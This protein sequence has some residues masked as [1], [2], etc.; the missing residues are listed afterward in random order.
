MSKLNRGHK[1]VY[2]IPVGAVAGICIYCGALAE[3]K[4][5]VPPLSAV[6]SLGA[7]YFEELL[8][9]PACNECNSTLGDK[10]LCEIEDRREFLLNNYKEKYKKILKSPS[11]SDEE[12]ASVGESLR[13]A[14]KGQEYFRRHLAERLDRL[15]SSIFNNE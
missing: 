7:D 5:H 10:W 9:V 11:W 14:I 3:T 2:K 4:D 8:V 13:S 15:S 6:S 1:A 12:L